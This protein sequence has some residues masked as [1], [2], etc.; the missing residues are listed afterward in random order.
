MGSLGTYI[1]FLMASLVLTL[2]SYPVSVLTLAAVVW[3]LAFL[4]KQVTPLLFKGNFWKKEAGGEKGWRNL[5]L[6]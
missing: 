3:E 4:A 2:I 6:E 1:P 5:S